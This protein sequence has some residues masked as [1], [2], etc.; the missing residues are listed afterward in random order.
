MRKRSACWGDPRQMPGYRQVE[1]DIRSVAAEEADLDTD[2]LVRPGQDHHH[3]GCYDWRDSEERA[4]LVTEMK[5]ATVESRAIR[6]D[7]DA[8]DG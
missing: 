3:G 6:A 4:D 1:V 5:R 2:S 7:A 8:P